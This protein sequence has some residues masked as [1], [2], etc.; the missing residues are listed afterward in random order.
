MR[1]SPRLIEVARAYVEGLENK[2]RQLETVQRDLDEVIF[3]AATM[4]NYNRTLTRVLAQITELVV[5]GKPITEDHLMNITEILE[6]NQIW[7][8]DIFVCS[9]GHSMFD[10]DAY[11]CQYLRCKPICG[12]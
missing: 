5:D 9:C 6:T 2:A 1:P 7:S 8:N 4:A 12:Q 11:G 3:Q 10:H